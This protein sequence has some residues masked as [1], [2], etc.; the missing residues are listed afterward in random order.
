MSELNF[1]K[2]ELNAEKWCGKREREL[3][4]P[5]KS[6]AAGKKCIELS[7]LSTLISVR[8]LSRTLH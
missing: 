4:L 6:T 5:I 3:Y 8:C 1:I 7:F 2:S